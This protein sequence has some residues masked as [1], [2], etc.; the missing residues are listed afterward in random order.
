MSPTRATAVQTARKA[1]RDMMFNGELPPGAALVEQQLAEKLG[2]SRT[3]I[4]EVLAELSQEG[5]IRNAGPWGKVVVEPTLQDAVE[6]YDLREIVEGAA[7]RLLAPH[8]TDEQLAE[9]ERRSRPLDTGERGA[10]DDLQFHQRIV[11]WCGNA[12]LLQ[13]AGTLQLQW[14]TFR[15]GDMMVQTGAVRKR[16]AQDIKV[17]HRQIVEALASRDSE[18]AE[19]VAR[20]H[21]RDIRATVLAAPR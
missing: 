12:R 16:P 2:V 13:F 6:L 4:R 9:L 10:R 7:A 17:T 3:P 20:A 5:L 8:I 11:S 21:V 18:V 1:I 15:F 19:Q 14:V